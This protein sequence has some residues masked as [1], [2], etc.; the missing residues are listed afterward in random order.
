MSVKNYYEYEKHKKIMILNSGLKNTEKLKNN[1]KETDTDSRKISR[2]FFE[3]KISA[4]FSTQ[5]NAAADGAG[6]GGNADGTAVVTND[7]NMMLSCPTG[8]I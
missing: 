5:N 3:K 7:G 1:V 2:D 8:L 6:G 4:K